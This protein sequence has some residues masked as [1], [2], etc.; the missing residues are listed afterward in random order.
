MRSLA[1]RT[2]LPVHRKGL[3]VQQAAEVVRT[4]LAAAEFLRVLIFSTMFVS[5]SFGEC[6]AANLVARRV[7]QIG[8][9]GSRKM[10]ARSCHAFVSTAI[11]EASGIEGVDLVGAGCG[12]ADGHAVA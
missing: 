11:G 12:K 9:I 3:L 4:C 2:E 1:C 5:A 7:A 6:V 8:G 10:A